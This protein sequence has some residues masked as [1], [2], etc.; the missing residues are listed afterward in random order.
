MENVLFN[1]TS[2]NLILLPLTLIG[3]EINVNHYT[4]LTDSLGQ[5][6]YSIE[7]AILFSMCIA[8]RQ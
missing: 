4:F 1:L 7:I 8:T 5:L 3:H 2:S 6:H